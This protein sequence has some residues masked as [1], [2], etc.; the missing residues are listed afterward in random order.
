MAL[1][2]VH[3]NPL[4]DEQPRHSS[5]FLKHQIKQ[6][7]FKQSRD[8]PKV[9]LVAH[10]AFYL[11][12][13]LRGHIRNLQNKGFAIITGGGA[14]GFE[15]R[16]DAMNVPF[17]PLPL[18][19]KAIHPIG[20]IRLFW[21]LYCWYRQEKP[22]I[23]HHFNIKAVIYG[24]VA[25]RLAKVPKIVN[26]I[27][28]L[29][30]A[31]SDEAKPWLKQ[32]VEWQYRIALSV[33][34][35][36]FFQNPDD[37]SLFV[38]RG[39]VRQEKTGLLPGS[40]VD[41]SYFAPRPAQPTTDQEQVIS[42]LMIG[43]L[44]K[45]KG[46]YEYVEAARLVKKE[47]PHARFYLVGRRDTLNPMAVS[48]EELEIWQAEGTLCWLGFIDDVRDVIAKMDVVVLPSYY[49][50]GIPRALLEAAAMG[51]P[52]IATDSVGCRE[53]VDHEVTGLLVP[54]KNSR[55]LAEAMSRMI[56]DPQMRQSMGMAGREKMVREFDEA[57]VIERVQNAYEI[58]KMVMRF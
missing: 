47:F 19:K 28:G 9:L 22:D 49:R 24:S 51:K 50:E 56:I 25:A 40:G 8:T 53:V 7:T 30:F 12:N 20:D 6:I 16:L 48:E 10:R 14:D 13:F 2:S 54:V 34:D 5:R 58:E 21:S 55:A 52:L 29:G 36:V 11:Q 23:V 57:I 4:D 15:N 18:P 17:V 35:T 1:K 27:T 44:L 37:H 31:F 3:S 26:T 45:D 39:L 33:A 38:Q 43:R 42:F 41:T 32:L 46:I